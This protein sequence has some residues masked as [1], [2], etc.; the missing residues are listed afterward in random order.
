MNELL[1]LCYTVKHLK[2]K[3]VMGR[4]YKYLQYRLE[5]RNRFLAQNLPGFSGCK[6]PWD[7]NFLQP[8]MQTNCASDIV[9]GKFTFL[10]NIQNV[11]WM[12]DWHCRH[13]PKLW[14]YNLHYFEWLWSLEYEDAKAVS[15]DWI[16]N[17]G[18]AKGQVG[19]EPYPISLRL[20]NLCGV[21]F[22][23]YRQ[24][25]IA[26]ESFIRQLWKSIYLQS[27]WLMRHLELHLLGN[28]YFENAVALAFVGSCFKGETAGKWLDKGLEILQ[29]EIP[30]Q[31]L[32]DGMHFELSP[33]Y[34]SRILYLLAILAATG[35]SNICDLVKE[36]L[37][38]M[39]RTLDCLCHPDCQI[40][41][42]N[43]SAFGI[44]NTP[45][46][47]ISYAGNFIK[48]V[49]SDVG[50]FALPNAGYYGF[51]G[52]DGTYLIC[53]AGQIGP[54]YIPG[55]AHADIFTF[56]LSLKGHRVVV[57]SGVNDYEASSMR[58][59][60]RSTKAHNTVE[61]GAQDQC[62]MWAAFRVARRGYP[63][64]VEWKTGENGFNLR[65]S[66]DG[67]K[68]LKGNPVHNRKFCWDKSGKLAVKDVVTASRPQTISSR[69]HLHPSCKID[70]LNNNSARVAYSG[71]SF[72]VTFYGN[73]NLSVQDSYY[74][75]EFGV[76]IPNKALTF[77]YSGCNTETEFKIESF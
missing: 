44:Y 73:G 26:N 10:N 52:N 4:I 48:V 72:E 35:N 63:Q 60:S 59:Y 3:Q 77:S 1:T 54:D 76:I 42:L 40:A 25:T 66:H 45:D 24:Q 46:Q 68:R 32:A 62:E 6:W 69:I 51:R 8:G 34:H 36:P 12:P 17:H 50:I 29:K 64:N 53:K 33:M 70:S 43:D 55:H 61:I 15:L 23:K 11:G 21:F 28:H 58:Q 18:I 49:N 71:G 67:Y 39:T 56:E 14:Q 20:M 38:R 9:V 41:L 65:A 30:E 75:P 2:C 5:N 74:C 7:V 22:G 31:I 37:K 16:A 27:Q 47:L 57:D 19:W 13:L